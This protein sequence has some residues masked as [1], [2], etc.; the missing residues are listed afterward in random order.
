MV[1]SERDAALVGFLQGQEFTQEQAVVILQGIR[2]NRE[3]VM[4]EIMEQFGG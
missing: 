4:A 3:D 1:E 2:E